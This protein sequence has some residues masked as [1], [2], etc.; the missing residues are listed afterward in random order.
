[1]ELI[2][3]AKDKESVDHRTM[4]RSAF[5]SAV[6]KLLLNRSLYLRVTLTPR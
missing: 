4:S 1:M 6:L 3:P 2:F 5:S